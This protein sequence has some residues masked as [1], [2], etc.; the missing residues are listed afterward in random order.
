MRAQILSNLWNHMPPKFVRT[1]P[2]LILAGNIGQLNSVRSSETM[3][4]VNQLSKGFTNVFWIPYAAETFNSDG[5][6]RCI[7][8]IKNEVHA[9]TD[10]K[11]LCNDVVTIGGKT[12]VATSG[13]RPGIGGAPNTI[14]VGW[15]CDEDQ[16][17]IKENASVDTVLISAGAMYC[18]KPKT[19]IIGTPPAG[20]E[21]MTAASDNQIIYTNSAN[22]KGFCAPAQF[23]LH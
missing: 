5:T 10:A 14:Q 21:N 7:E 23:E 17:F 4:L 3:N 16:D 13:W 9:H 12:L 6:A 15:W 18:W 1:A 19:V 11:M 22:H 20:Y 2:T 8:A